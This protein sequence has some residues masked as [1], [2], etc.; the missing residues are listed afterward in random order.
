MYKQTSK[1][2]YDLSEVISA[3][4]KCVRRGLEAEAMYWTVELYESGFDEYCWKRLR[5]MASEDVGLAEP[6]MPAS[7]AALYQLYQELKK[8][9]DEHQRPERLPLTHAVFLLCRARKSRVI[10]NALVHFWGSHNETRLEVPDFALDKHTA[11]GRT[12]GRGFGHFLE[13]GAHL[14][15]LGQVEGE[16]Q[17]REMFSR[18]VSP[19]P[20]FGHE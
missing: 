13:V 7:I 20:L 3:L 2:G 17:Y 6:L 11:R 8:K 16:Q 12:M 5:I 4:Q 1:K 9:K 10:D 19:T 14:E 18:T 15:N